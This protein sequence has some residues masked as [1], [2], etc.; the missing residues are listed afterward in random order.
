MQQGDIVLIHFPFT[1]FQASKLRPALIISNIVFNRYANFV[2]LPISTKI[3]PKSYSIPLTSLDLKE[4]KLL[5]KSYIRFSSIMS[6]EKRLIIKKVATLD[7]AKI[8][9]VREKVISFF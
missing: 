2:L 9:L 6:I 4:G 5:K 8:L 7:E 3:G 1:D